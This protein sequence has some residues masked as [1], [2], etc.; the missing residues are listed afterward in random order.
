MFL[1]EYSP[2]GIATSIHGLLPDSRL[3]LS[4]SD[5]WV[6]QKPLVVSLST[7]ISH[8]FLS[9]HRVDVQPR[10]CLVWSGDRIWGSWWILGLLSISKELASP[11]QPLDWVHCKHVVADNKLYF[12]QKF[13]GVMSWYVGCIQHLNKFLTL[14]S[15]KPSTLIRQFQT[16]QL[17][18]HN[19]LRRKRRWELRV[20]TSVSK[21]QFSSIDNRQGCA[22]DM[23]DTN[24][25]TS[26]CLKAKI[27]VKEPEKA[28][29]PS[30]KKSKDWKEGDNTALNYKPMKKGA[31]TKVYCWSMKMERE[32]KLPF[33]FSSLDTGLKF[34]T[35]S[36]LDS[37]AMD[38]F[39]DK[40]MIKKHDIT[41]ETLPE[42]IAVYN[43]DSRCSKLRDITGY[44]TL[45]MVHSLHKE[46]MCLYT[47]SLRKESILIGH[48]W[49]K[50]HNPV[51]NWITSKA[52]M[53]QCPARSCR[54]EHQVK[55]AGKKREHQKKWREVK[56]QYVKFKQ[57]M[58]DLKHK[59]HQPTCEEVE[60]E[61]NFERRLHSFILHPYE[62][63]LSAEWSPS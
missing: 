36:L 6:Y 42:P 34:S 9:D 51:I 3:A 37:G 39:I 14:T 2:C 26:E 27:S 56:E 4:W 20:A 24:D 49:L 32:V 21:N 17:L 53:S 33:L 43:T 35:R 44:I 55:L 11:W 7:Q 31:Q 10:R 22:P 57:N 48:D 19:K 16:W 28:E 58:E 8:L 47:T 18:W 62:W 23:Y 38:S 60:D 13:L 63:D 30:Q 41:V 5:L 59:T 25:N 1:K 52:E 12:H 45:E 46:L 29:Q 15:T 50:K 61:Y 40:G 54:Y